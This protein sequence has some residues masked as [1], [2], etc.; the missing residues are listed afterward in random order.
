MVERKIME[1]WVSNLNEHEFRTLVLLPL[2]K[3]L[4]YKDVIHYHGGARELG[5]DIIMWKKTDFKQRESYAV[6]VKV[7]KITG[8]VSGKNSFS[9]II[10]QVQ[11]ALG[12]RYRD[13]S[14]LDE[15]E[16]D[17]CL[18]AVNIPCKK[19]TIEA[20]NA[21]IKS[22]K[23]SRL[24]SF[25]GY[26]T[27][28]DYL[29]TYKI[30]PNSIDSFSQLLDL[31]DP[32][33]NIREISVER[34]GNEKKISIKFNEN[35]PSNDLSGSFSIKIPE[36]HK[37]A[38]FRKSYQEFIDNGSILEIPK[39][40][41]ASFSTPLALQKLGPSG[42]I[43]KIVIGPI[44]NS[45]IFIWDLIVKNAN[46]QISV[47]PNVNLMINA[48]G[49]KSVTLLHDDPLD[50]FMIFITINFQ[51]TMNISWEI[52]DNSKKYTVVEMNRYYSFVR[53]L[54]DGEELLLVD[55]KKQIKLAKLKLNSTKSEHQDIIIYDLYKK[56]AFIQETINKPLYF[57]DNG[58]RKNDVTDINELYSII[59][60]GCMS[61]ITGTF[62]LDF[63]KNEAIIN[64]LP[65]SD[66]FSDINLM[67]AVGQ[68]YEILG[69]SIDIGTVRY[70]IPKGII[71]HQITDDQ[72][73]ISI[74]VDHNSPAT[75]FYEKYTKETTK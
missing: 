39:E 75:A 22:L 55:S 27:L 23:E 43:D 30:G 12:S 34:N 35:I 14:T 6:V 56:A 40:F 29:L 33:N 63:N 45:E 38:Q 73:S 72:I 2:F 74:T 65:E 62:T 47:L 3:E 41:I 59:T 71:K 46:G 49:Q 16:I 18:I 17:H 32:G 70:I 66:G 42:E 61:N 21:S 44:M 64:S 36:G 5:K 26:N 60:E 57:P 9:E 11:Q 1:D 52:K 31:N 68:C 7:G 37:G 24:I 58:L 51:R 28:I 25:L 53:S 8:S 19:E 15:Y 67:L 48:R 20:I 69:E 4:G 50:P 54:V 13:E 10:T